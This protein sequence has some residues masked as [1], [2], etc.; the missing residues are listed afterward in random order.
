MT[1]T[2]LHAAI[3]AV[4]PVDCVR[5]GRQSDRATWSFVASSSATGSEITAGNNVLATID[6][7]ADVLPPINL[8]AV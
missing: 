2:Q 8:N 6:P 3:K 5:V 7:G 1:A 4:C